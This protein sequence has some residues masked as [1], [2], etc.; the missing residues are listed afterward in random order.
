ML[1]PRA[2]ELL[3]MVVNNLYPNQDRL[4]RINSAKKADVRKVWSNHC[5]NCDLGVVEDCVHLF[6]EC[7]KVQEGW[8][9]VRRRVMNLLQDYQGLSNFELLHL[10]FPEEG[11]VEN[12]VIWLVGNWVQLVYEEGVVRGS[13]LKDQFVRGHYR[14]KF[15]ESLN[16][17]MPQLNYIQDVTVLDPG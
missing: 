9:W 4:F 2:R 13:T 3:Y 15:M 10:T 14:Y 6:M 8:L 12:E 17:K 7:K 1:E 11:H 5:K 16:M